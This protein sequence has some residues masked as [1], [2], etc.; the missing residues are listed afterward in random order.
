MYIRMNSSTYL[1]SLNN[2][3]MSISEFFNSGCDNYFCEFCFKDGSNAFGVITTFFSDMP[4]VYLFLKGTDRQ[5]YE[6]FERLKDIKG[7]KSLCRFID[8]ETIASARR[9]N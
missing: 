9:L 7:M 3:L 1:Y 5:E 8:L 6:K 2:N 4:Q